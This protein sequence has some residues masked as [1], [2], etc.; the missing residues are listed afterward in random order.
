MSPRPGGQ[1]RLSQ[2]HS[3]S[4]PHSSALLASG[5]VES[6]LENRAEGSSG[7]L[8]F[9]IALRMVLIIGNPLTAVHLIHKI[10]CVEMVTWIVGNPRLG[11]DRVWALIFLGPTFQSAWRALAQERHLPPSWT[12]L[13][14]PPSTVL[15]SLAMRGTYRRGPRRNC[16]FVQ[17]APCQSGSQV[18]P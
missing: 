6:T 3:P 2:L 7:V 13:P 4:W 5:I 17:V 12:F 18:N 8:G 9:K 14:S 15:H 10:S 11:P 1:A 16:N